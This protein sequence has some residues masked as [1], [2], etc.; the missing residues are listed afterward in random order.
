MWA[1]EAQGVKFNMTLNH[2]HVIFKIDNLPEQEIGNVRGDVESG[3]L[4][5]EHFIKCNGIDEGWI[6]PC[7][8]RAAV[9]DNPKN[10]D[11]V[12]DDGNSGRGIQY[13][14]KQPEPGQNH[15]EWY[16][17]ASKSWT[18][19]IRSLMR[20]Y[21]ADPNGVLGQISTEFIPGPVC[22]QGCKYS[23]FEQRIEC[24]RWMRQTSNEI[25][26]AV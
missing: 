1:I 20:Y 8:A 13:P 4:I 23:L 5:L 2:S 24:V 3:K 7:H 6:R 18:E 26:E 21:A 14:F 17:E 19:S 11:T 22:S 10:L 9:S 15:L 16:E 12:K 25:R